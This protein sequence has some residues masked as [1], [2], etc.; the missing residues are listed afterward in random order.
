MIKPSKNKWGIVFAQCTISQKPR[1]L[2]PENSWKEVLLVRCILRKLYSLGNLEI[3]K[4]VFC[5]ADWNFYIKSTREKGERRRTIL[6]KV[7]F[8]FFRMGFQSH[9]CHLGIAAEDALCS[10]LMMINKEA[11]SGIMN[12]AVSETPH[13]LSFLFFPSS[14]IGMC[15]HTQYCTDHLSKGKWPWSLNTALV[16]L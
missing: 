13:G 15:L 6:H 5:G 12:L 7:F 10:I 4:L 9:H 2:Q 1:C 14:G 11:G 8:F 16:F 3:G